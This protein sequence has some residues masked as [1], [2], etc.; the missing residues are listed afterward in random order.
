MLCDA[1]V[2]LLGPAAGIGALWL[3]RGWHI[4]LLTCGAALLS[5]AILLFSESLAN[6]AAVAAFN[7]IPNPTDA[8]MRDFASDGATMGFFFVL[9]FPFFFLYGLGWFALARGGRRLIR[10]QIHA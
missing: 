4:T 8:Q 1:A 2:A 5:W 7:R 6:A 9:G 10:R 3:K